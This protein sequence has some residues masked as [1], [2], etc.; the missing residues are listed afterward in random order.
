MTF[1]FQTKELMF[2]AWFLPGSTSPGLANLTTLEPCCLPHL[3]NRPYLFSFICVIFKVWGFQ[4]NLSAFF[5]PLVT[6]YRTASCWGVIELNR[7]G[8]LCKML[9]VN[10]LL[11]AYSK[12]CSLLTKC[13]SDTQ[14]PQNTH[15]YIILEVYKVVLVILYI[16]MR[17]FDKSISRNVTVEKILL[18][19]IKY[20]HIYSFKCIK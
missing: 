19:M 7:S 17:A 20:I 16:Y 14:I 8:I 3:A 18:N 10:S 6:S 4:H 11:N 13:V 2:V 1:I 9:M 15:I 5:F 12:Q